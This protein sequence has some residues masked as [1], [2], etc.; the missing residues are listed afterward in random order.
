M[1]FKAF[2]K[3]I[4]NSSIQFKL[5]PSVTAVDK[6]VA[7]DEEFKAPAWLRLSHRTPTISKER[8]RVVAQGD[9][10][11]PH[12]ASK[13]I[14]SNITPKLTFPWSKPEHKH[15]TPVMDILRSIARSSPVSSTSGAKGTQTR[16]QCDNETSPESTTSVE[17]VANQCTSLVLA[18]GSLADAS[19]L[20]QRSTTVEENIVVFNPASFRLINDTAPYLFRSAVIVNQHIVP[21]PTLAEYTALE[22]EEHTEHDQPAHSESDWAVVLYRPAQSEGVIEVDIPAA[23]SITPEEVGEDEDTDSS[24]HSTTTVATSPDTSYAVA[25][26]EGFK[27]SQI[28]I[29]ADVEPVEQETHDSNEQDECDKLREELSHQQ[30]VSQSLR[31]Q[32]LEREDEVSQIH[33]ELKTTRSER[34]RY[35]AEQDKADVEIRKLKQELANK[36]RQLAAEKARSASAIQEVHHNTRGLSNQQLISQRDDAYQVAKQYF[37]EVQRLQQMLN[38]TS[39]ARATLE[40]QVDDWE[41]QNA[42]TQQQIVD[43]SEEVSARL[44]QANDT[45]SGLEQQNV[46]L[47]QQ[48]ERAEGQVKA[49][50]K[51]ITLEYLEDPSPPFNPQTTKPDEV[52]D[53]TQALE[54]TQKHCADLKEHMNDLHR[55]SV[56]KAKENAQLRTDLDVQKTRA[57]RLSAGF[58]ILRNKLANWTETLPLYAQMKDGVDIDSV[59]GLKEA[60]DQSALHEELV[61]KDLRDHAEAV[62]NLELKLVKVERRHSRKLEEVQKR[63]AELQ[64]RNIRLDGE[65]FNLSTRVEEIEVLQGQVKEMTNRA[66]EWRMQAMEQT[67]GDTAKIIHNEHKEEVED[68]RNQV[69]ALNKRIWEW[70]SAYDNVA[71]DLNMIQWRTAK[72]MGDVRELEAERDW[73]QAW[74]NALKER[75]EVELLAIPINIPWRSDFSLLNTK[76]H[77]ELVAREDMIIDALTGCNM[78]R[79]EELVQAAAKDAKKAAEDE[80]PRGISAT[81][82]WAKLVQEYVESQKTTAGQ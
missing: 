7:S 38:A 37:N 58:E 56:Q 43:F 81:D 75:F 77:I 79:S 44:E 17:D 82:I 10:V 61:T 36:D 55:D 41:R 76:N 68:L 71:L 5:I 20:L 69:N 28:Y 42:Q 29:H 64:E 80:G 67:Y 74:V 54:M 47:L 35:E 26:Q 62:S 66:E 57:A 15:Q 50:N 21:G 45:I 24:F 3:E 1:G 32:V 23:G 16:E 11:V 18:R 34:D 51:K 63:M 22:T 39:G 12:T 65:N 25:E 78:G 59:P 27:P 33:G 19:Q 30:S 70:S 60:L 8:G 52:R 40:Q 46:H 72:S 2:F 4:I 53:L 6:A 48:K 49:L 13:V 73:Y 14:H 9:M 31:S